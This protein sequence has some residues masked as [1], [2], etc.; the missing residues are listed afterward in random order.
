LH[1]EAS[2]GG[3]D[4]LRR[5]EGT[6]SAEVRTGL[7]AEGRRSQL[8]MQKRIHEWYDSGGENKA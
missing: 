4:P 3:G 6:I 8:S 7:V 5:E 2:G 1:K